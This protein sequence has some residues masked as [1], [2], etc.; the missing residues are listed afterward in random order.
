MHKCISRSIY[1]ILLFFTPADL[2]SGSPLSSA[3]LVYMNIRSETHL[4]LF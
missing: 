4:C 3:Q 2:T 1:Y